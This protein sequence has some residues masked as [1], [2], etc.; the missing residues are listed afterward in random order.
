V[1]PSAERRPAGTGRQDGGETI[2]TR[3]T[4]RWFGATLYSAET[5]RAGRDPLRG[6]AVALDHLDE[7]GLCACW[8]A[9]RRHRR[10]A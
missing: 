8:V 10:A 6:L 2:G 3:I 9:P 1:P 7:L 4:E 5:R